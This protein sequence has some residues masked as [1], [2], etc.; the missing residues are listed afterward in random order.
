[1]LAV[2]T[3][4]LVMSSSALGRRRR[5]GEFA[6]YLFAGLILHGLLASV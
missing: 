6:V 3:F 4:V 1:M 5:A 2:Y